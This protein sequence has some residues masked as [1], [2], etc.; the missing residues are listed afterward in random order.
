[1]CAGAQQQSAAERR[2]GGGRRWVPGRFSGAT[3]LVA[4]GRADADPRAPAGGGVCRCSSRGRAGGRS[5]GIDL[6]G[7]P[8][9]ASACRLSS[10][11]QGPFPKS[12]RGVLPSCRAQLPSDMY[13]CAVFCG[14]SEAAADPPAHGRWSPRRSAP[15]SRSLRLPS[16]P[17]SRQVGALFGEIASAA[18]MPHMKGLRGPRPIEVIAQQ[19]QTYPHPR[20]GWISLISFNKQGHL[21]V[22][23]RFGA[24]PSAL[25]VMQAHS[26]VQCQPHGAEPCPEGVRVF[27]P[28]PNRRR[29]QRTHG[30]CSF[31][32]KPCSYLPEA[33]QAQQHRHAS[34]TAYPRSVVL[35]LPSTG[36]LLPF[37]SVSPLAL[38]LSILLLPLPASLLCSLP[39]PPFSSPLLPS[40]YPSPSVP[41]P[42]SSLSIPSVVPGSSGTLLGLFPEQALPASQGGGKGEA[43]PKQ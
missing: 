39:S 35:R 40:P 33:S 43:Q 34:A 20:R 1:V 2:E 3:S 21:F 14:A 17:L 16:T 24:V 5:S 31:S 42:L 18:S 9:H 15:G 37:R 26:F 25:R 28:L 10:Q 30:S 41:H 7:L 29:P 19:A 38:P 27:R 8:T 13:E 32:A 4:Q 36:A 23:P 22:E 6:S 11:L 12:V